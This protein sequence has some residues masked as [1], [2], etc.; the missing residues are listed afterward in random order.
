MGGAIW[1]RS[2]R[3]CRRSWRR[4]R[5][6]HHHVPASSRALRV[7][8]AAAL[9]CVA[10]CP[11]LSR[12]DRIRVADAGRDQHG[13][14]NL[15]KSVA[16]GWIAT[17]VALN[18]PAGG[19]TP[20]MLHADP[21]GS[22]RELYPKNVLVDPPNFISKA[23]NQIF[24]TGAPEVKAQPTSLTSQLPSEFTRPW[25]WPGQGQPGTACWRR[26][27]GL[28]SGSL[29]SRHG[30]QCSV[31]SDARLEHSPGTSSRPRRA[32]RRPWRRGAKL[33]LGKTE[34]ARL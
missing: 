27:A 18:D 24:K 28:S 15:G 31:W 14:D 9:Q 29:P 8:R 7:R 21:S 1:P 23:F 19:L 26:A 17:N 33:L 32:S 10:G 13:T 4:N 6:W 12:D 20:T 22:A 16:D 11:H 34:Q 3:I 2:P 25:L 5:E 30:R